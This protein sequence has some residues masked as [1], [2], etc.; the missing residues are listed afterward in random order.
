MELWLYHFIPPTWL[1]ILKHLLWA[2]SGWFFILHFFFFL[3]AHVPFLR[4]AAV[5]PILAMANWTWAGPWPGVASLQGALHMKNSTSTRLSGSSQ[6]PKHELGITAPEGQSADGTRRGRKEQL[7]QLTGGHR[8][9][10]DEPP[11]STPWCLRYLNCIL[12]FIHFNSS[13]TNNNGNKSEDSVHPSYVLWA[14]QA[15]LQVL[16]QSLSSIILRR[17]WWWHWAQTF[18]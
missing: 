9:R 15:L 13:N 4:S 12:V 3:F 6:S 8:D 10:G 11:P 14:F 17:R 7:S 1:I 18:K 16:M 5:R 2:L